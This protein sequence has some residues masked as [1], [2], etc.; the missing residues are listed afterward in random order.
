[1]TSETFATGMAAEE[2]AGEEHSTDDE[3]DAGHDSH[4]CGHLIEPARLV[5]DNDR[6][7]RLMV[8]DHRLRCWIG[9]R[10]RRGRVF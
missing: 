6:P 3:D 10:D 2:E 5:T 8:L 9:G 7:L 4:P 1:M